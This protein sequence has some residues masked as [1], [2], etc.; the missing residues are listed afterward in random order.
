MIIKKPRSK[1]GLVGHYWGSIGSNLVRISKSLLPGRWSVLWNFCC[2]FSWKQFPL[3]LLVKVLLII[4]VLSEIQSDSQVAVERKTQSKGHRYK[5][6][7][8][9]LGFLMLSVNLWDQV[10][11]KCTSEKVTF[12]FLLQN[13]FP[14]V[15]PSLFLILSPH[16][17]RRQR[18][19]QYGF[20]FC[21][22]TK[23]LL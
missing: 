19:F 9:C 15:N 21:L 11:L 18:C 7:I 20:L 16:F 12:K 14:N 3:S 6:E 8:G 5:M 13:V 1:Y 22:S 4:P 2:S 10:R 17:Y 23:S